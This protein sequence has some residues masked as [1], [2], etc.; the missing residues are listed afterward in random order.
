MEIIFTAIIDRYKYP[1]NENNSIKA[2][3]DRLRNIRSR[4]L[5]YR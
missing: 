1:V 2:D 5:I 4:C 3:A